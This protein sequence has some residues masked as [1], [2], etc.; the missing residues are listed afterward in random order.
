MTEVARSVS[1]TDIGS[2]KEYPRP[3]PKYEH[4]K[5]TGADI[6]HNTEDEMA[7][8][9]LFLGSS[10]SSPFDWPRLDTARVV[11]GLRYGLVNVR[12]DGQ[13]LFFAQKEESG[14]DWA[15]SVLTSQQ[16]AQAR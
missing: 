10:Q 6:V 1:V 2:M 8:F 15:W 12:T 7:R 11:G 5:P 16:I 4:D 14:D 13:R 9:R 3:R